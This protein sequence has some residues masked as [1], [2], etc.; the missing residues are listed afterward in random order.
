ML[1]RRHILTGLVTLP[2]AATQVRAGGAPV[3]TEGQLAIQGIDPVSYF[4]DGG[5]QPG[6]AANR[7]IWLGAIW[8]FS[9]LQTMAMFERDP[10]GLSPQYGGY[11]A[12][13]LALGSLAASIPEAWAM[14]DNKLYLHNTVAAR[15]YWQQSPSVYLAKSDANWPTAIC[16]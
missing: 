14:H 7:L 16:R 15:D 4:L 1:N 8:Q 10:Y 12:T 3:Y 6:Q 2:F 9:S 13:T 11:C 5:P